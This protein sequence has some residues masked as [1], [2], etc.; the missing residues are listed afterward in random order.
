MVDLNFILVEVVVIV[1][2]VALKIWVHFLEEVVEDKE[3]V[4]R[5]DEI[6]DLN[7]IMIQLKVKKLKF[8][9]AK[10]L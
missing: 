10:T 3:E 4:D 8:K 6:K 2:L 7:K 1:D 5:E 9:N